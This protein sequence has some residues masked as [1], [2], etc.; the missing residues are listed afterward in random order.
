MRGKGLLGITITVLLATPEVV[1]AGQQGGVSGATNA[2]G[3][4]LVDTAVGVGTST[5]V[6]L[7]VTGTATAVGATVTV[8]GSA[9]TGV[10]A[11]TGVGGAVIVAAGGGYAI[12]NGIGSIQVGSQTI[13]DHI[14]D[15][16][17]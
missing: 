13:H 17:I 1:Q 3:G 16:I 10:V 9:V 12:G 5:A 4:V 14:A 15:G 6:G 11:S 2:A 7:G 8:G